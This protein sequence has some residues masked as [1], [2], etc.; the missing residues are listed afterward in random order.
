MLAAMIKHEDLAAQA[1]YEASLAAFER[2]GDVF[3]RS[4]ALSA[5]GGLAARQRDY[6]AARV[7]YEES[8]LIAQRVSTQPE[9]LHT[10]WRLLDIELGLR[11]SLRGLADVLEA[12]GH[13][14]RAA[15][16]SAAAAAAGQQL[17]IQQAIELAI[18]A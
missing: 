4:I 12:E 5:L 16:L 1:N 7:L 11:L 8:V 6:S 18:A 13:P 2:A 3:G 9:M 15:R 14:E 10:R 17:T